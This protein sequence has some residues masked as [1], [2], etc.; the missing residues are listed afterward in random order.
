MAGILVHLPPMLAGS[1]NCRSRHGLP[2]GCENLAFGFCLAQDSRLSRSVNGMATTAPP[3]TI[4]L[5]AERG[6]KGEGCAMP[7]KHRRD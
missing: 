4:L 2:R 3:A 1:K 6:V 5:Q 7:L